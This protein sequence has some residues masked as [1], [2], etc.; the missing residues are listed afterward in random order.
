MRL[1]YFLALY[2]TINPKWIKGLNIRLETIE[3]LEGIIDR[4][5][6]DIYLTS[7]FF[8]L[9]KAKEIKAKMKNRT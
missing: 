7:N 4:T 5:P 6:F 8:Y 2:T 9:P 3:L 1:E